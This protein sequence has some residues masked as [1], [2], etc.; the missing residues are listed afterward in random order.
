MHT[1]QLQE[2]WQQSEERLWEAVALRLLSSHLA[3]PRAK[4]VAFLG[5]TRYCNTK[6]S[7][8]GVQS[9]FSRS[10]QIRTSHSLKHWTSQTQTKLT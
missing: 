4:Y 5:A 8:V 6:G 1:L 7:Q 2:V 3:D 10:N 9:K